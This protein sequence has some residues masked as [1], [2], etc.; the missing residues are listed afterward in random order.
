MNPCVSKEAGERERWGCI[1]IYRVEGEGE[2][3]NLRDVGASHRAGDT[4][5]DGHAPKEERRLRAAVVLAQGLGLAK[6]IC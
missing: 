2:S 5:D 6:Y 1:Y 4:R 3:S